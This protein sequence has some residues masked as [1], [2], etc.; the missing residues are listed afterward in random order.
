MTKDDISYLQLIIVH[1]LVGVVIYLIPALSLAYALAMFGGGL[2]FIISNRNQNSEVLLACAYVVGSEVFLRMTEGNPIYEFSKYSTVIFLLVGVYYQGFSTRAVPYWIFLLLLIPGLVLATQTSHLDRSMRKIISFN[3]SGEIALG[4]AALYCYGRQITFARLNT[5]LLWMALPLI[6]MVVYLILY[7][8]SVREVITTTN[9][10]FETSA[11]FGPNQVATAL[12]LG[13]FIFFSR[14]MFTTKSRFIFVVNIALG[15]IVTYRGL[16]TFSRGGMITGFAMFLVLL[17]LTYFSARTSGRTKLHYLFISLVVAVFAM[18][19]YSSMQTSGLIDKRYSNQDAL[20]REKEDRLTGRENIAASELGYFLENPIFGVGVAQ[21]AELRREDTGVFIV[22][23]N[24]ITRMMAEH[25][26]FGI[27]ALII[28]L[29]TPLILYLD[30][31]NNLYLLAFVV[32]WLLTINHTAMRMAAP[33][34]V[35]ALSLLKVDPD[36]VYPVHR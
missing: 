21:G 18:W 33:A 26:V 35:Y 5:V 22:S 24:E 12:G 4:I 1:I 2:A 10:N 27:I 16:V 15:L 34:F 36:E 14:L 6:S 32:F 31:K 8:P 19:S 7:T 17:V 25:G 23:H 29:F 20:G 9:S 30:N 3:I 13:T 28:L 11:G